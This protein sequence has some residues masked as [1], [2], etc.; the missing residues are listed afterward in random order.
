MNVIFVNNSGPHKISVGA[1][2]TYA[3]A[4][5]TKRLNST[6]EM[7][8]QSPKKLIVFDWLWSVSIYVEKN[9]L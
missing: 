2:Q 7:A 3:R 6:K 4:R 8:Q 5:H 9:R 1:T